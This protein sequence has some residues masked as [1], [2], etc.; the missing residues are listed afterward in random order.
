MLVCRLAWNHPPLDGNKLAACAALV[1]FIDLNDGVWE[2]DTP[3][4]DEAEEAMA[5]IAVGEV[6]EA[7]VV[8]WLRERVRFS[9]RG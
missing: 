1:M 9:D 7:W 5:A 4:V 6:D 8:N 3:E 2:P